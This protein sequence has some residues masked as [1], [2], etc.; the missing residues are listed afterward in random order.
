LCNAPST[1]VAVSIVGGDVTG[2]TG[3]TLGGERVPQALRTR[4]DVAATSVGLTPQF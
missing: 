3:G 4:S 1:I 2:D